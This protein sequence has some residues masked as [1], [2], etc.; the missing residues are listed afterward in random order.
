M[1]RVTAQPNLLL[2]KLDTEGDSDKLGRAM[3]EELE[4][5]LGAETFTPFVITMTDGLY[6]EVSD[7]RKTLIGKR[8]LVVMDA[9]GQFV[10]IPFT[11]IRLIMSI[12]H[13]SEPT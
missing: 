4:T 5:R 6:V 9:D 13:P 2:V 10:H 7:P 3:K 8:M 11:S 12:S 1:G